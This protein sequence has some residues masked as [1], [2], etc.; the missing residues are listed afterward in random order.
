M[1]S[2]FS[3]PVDEHRYLPWH[4]RLAVRQARTVLFYAFLVGLVLSLVQILNDY[5]SQREDLSGTLEQLMESIQLP[6]QNAVWFVDEGL[7]VGVIEGLLGYEPILQ[8]QLSYSEGVLFEKSKDLHSEHNWLIRWLFGEQYRRVIELPPPEAPNDPSVGQI[9]LEIDPAYAGRAF[10]HRSLVVVGSGVAR[11]L[12]L[13]VIL[14]LLFLFTLT[15]PV[16]AVSRFVRSYQPNAPETP[17]KLSI[18]EAQLQGELGWLYEDTQALMQAVDNSQVELEKRVQARTHALALSK[19]SLE[20]ISACVMTVD[21]Q[22]NVIYTNPS[23][24]AL[25]SSVFGE[26]WQKNTLQAYLPSAS[27]FID[28][29][30]TKS[31]AVRD[32][33]SVQGRHLSLHASPVNDHNTGEHVGYTIEWWDQ[34]IDI[35]RQN[36]TREVIAQAKSGAL[37]QRLPVDI[38]HPHYQA[39]NREVNEFLALNER[40]ISEINASLSALAQG[41]LN[42]QLSVQDGGAFGHMQRNVN[43]TLEKLN[44]VIEQL[45]DVTH[46]VVLGSDKI[47]QVTAKLHQFNTEFHGELTESISEM[48][49]L[50]DSVSD[51]AERA[52]SADAM[53]LSVQEKAQAGAEIVNNTGHAVASIAAS[54]E[55]IANITEDINSIAFQTNLLAL[56]AAVEAARAGSSGKGFAVVATEVQGLSERSSNAAQKISELTGQNALKVDECTDW[57]AKS[58]RTLEDIVSTAAEASQMVAKVTASGQTQ[59]DSLGSVSRRMSHLHQSTGEI[60]ACV[61]EAATVSDQMIARVDKLAGI[62]GFFQTQATSSCGKSDKTG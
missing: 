32:T 58:G 33:L 56:N 28:Q 39:L 37:E 47:H 5:R 45:G 12:L 17:K 36:Q 19:Q 14:L 21:T 38:T 53:S 9:T 49:R 46:T 31:S 6:A 29:L 42:A 62:V 13:S 55:K 24:Q 50:S 26:P 57:I 4:K 61:S 25:L 1:D 8:A 11:T 41:Q 16:V 43:H 2:E 34:S 10:L 22:L 60:E 48:T 23:L 44:E 54:S 59:A 51:N 18:P 20:C 35:Q 27:D 7:A 40:V 3:D 30:S 52:Q 15:R